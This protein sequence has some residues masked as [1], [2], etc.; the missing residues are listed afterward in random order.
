MFNVKYHALQQFAIRTGT[1]LEHSSVLLN[2][3]LNEAKEI[4]YEEATEKYSILWAK[5]GDT[6]LEFRIDSIGE[7]AIAIRRKDG[8]VVTI[9]TK[10]IYGF[11]K[12]VHAHSKVGRGMKPLG[13]NKKRVDKPYMV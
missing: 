8:A 1:R 3:Y 11:S 12:R 13:K 7:E 9:L 4:P 5:P 6:Y 2:R 10:D